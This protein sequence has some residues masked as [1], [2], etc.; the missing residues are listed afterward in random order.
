MLKITETK[1]AELFLHSNTM[2]AQ[3]PHF[4]PKVPRKGVGLINLSSDGGDA[5]SGEA[6]GCFTN[7]VSGLAEGEIH[8]GIMVRDHDGKLSRADGPCEAGA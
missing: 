1:A 7:G 8:G 2:Q 3:G 6:R 4:R 5:I